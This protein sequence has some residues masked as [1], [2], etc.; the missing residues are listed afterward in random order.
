MLAEQRGCLGL[1]EQQ[2]VAAAVQGQAEA[3]SGCAALPACSCVGR[4]QSA[5]L[6]VCAFARHQRPVYWDGRGSFLKTVP[7]P[8]CRYRAV[9]KQGDLRLAL[10]CG[11]VFRVRMH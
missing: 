8:M 1:A 4:G 3:A 5:R 2:A 7:K 9:L 11:G 6:P 10:V